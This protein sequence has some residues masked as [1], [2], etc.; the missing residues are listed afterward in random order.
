MISTRNFKAY[1]GIL[2]GLVLIVSGCN[3]IDK[4]EDNQFL[5]QTD[6]RNIIQS[7]NGTIII[8]P[9]GTLVYEDGATIEEPVNVTLREAFTLSG[10]LE[11]NLETRSSGKLLVTGGMID[12]DVSVISGRKVI[13]SDRKEMT[14]QVAENVLDTNSYKLFNQ[15]GKNWENPKNVDSFLTYLPIK[16]HQT[17]YAYSNGPDSMALM[18]NV[19]YSKSLNAIKGNK[20]LDSF[21]I[22][23]FLRNKYN[24]PDF[25]N[26]EIIDKSFLSSKEYEDRFLQIAV[27]DEL[28][29]D[30]HRT[31]IK[32]IDKPLWGADS[33]V[34]EMLNG[35]RLDLEKRGNTSDFYYESLVK[36]IDKVLKFKNQ[37]KTTFSEERLTK[38]ELGLLKKAYKKIAVNQVIQSYSIRKLGWHNID[39]F[40]NQ[41]ELITT[42]L[43]IKCN[44]DAKRVVIIFKDIKSVVQA[45]KNKKAQYCFGFGGECEVKLPHLKAYIIA[46]AEKDGQLLFAKKEIQIGQNEVEELE[47]KPSSQKEISKVLEDIEKGYE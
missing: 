31:Y 8:I 25:F 46:M 16:N 15:N 2:F 21:S 19:L 6:I 1:W 45:K 13:I 24:I 30:V 27:W 43:S 26:D 37:Y 47:L 20:L 36:T 34:L 18:E 4:K 33:V 11:N 40:Y 3:R 41:S 29:I 38:E 12:I 42:E 7:V 23:V 5:I 17:I 14:L 44:A 9:S 32:N 28:S 22:E 35:Y 39:Y 10:I